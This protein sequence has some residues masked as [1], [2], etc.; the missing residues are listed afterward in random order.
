MLLVMQ[1]FIKEQGI[2]YWI[3]VTLIILMIDMNNKGWSLF[4]GVEWRRNICLGG[5]TVRN[6]IKGIEYKDVNK[7]AININI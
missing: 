2:N 6:F 5:V 3:V 4:I 7:M 1:V